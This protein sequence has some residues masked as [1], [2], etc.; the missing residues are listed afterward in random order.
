[1]SEGN[2]YDVDGEVG[3]PAGDGEPVEEAAARSRGEHVG[4]VYLI[5][6]GDEVHVW[7][8]SY[9]AGAEARDDWT[10]MAAWWHIDTAR[11]RIA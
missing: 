8:H 11:R 6:T 1:M 2:T 7:S 9:P 5:D 3:A 10:V 4:T